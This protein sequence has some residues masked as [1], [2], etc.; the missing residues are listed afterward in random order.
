[1]IKR[2]KPTTD[3]IRIGSTIK[4]TVT[5]GL[6]TI[7][8]TAGT[9]SDA[10]VTLRSTVELIHGALQ[11]PIIEQRIDLA[12]TIHDGLSKLKAAGMT[13]EQAIAYL[14]L[15]TALYSSD[16]QAIPAQA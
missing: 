7:E 13:Q 1:M 5:S 16:T 11:E 14:Q 3:K 10:V 9:I 4:S 8:E 2:N 12:T 15:D 6:S